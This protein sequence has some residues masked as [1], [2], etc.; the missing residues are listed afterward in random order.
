MLWGIVTRSNVDYAELM[1]EEFIQA[2][3]IFFTHRVN[4]NIPT[5]KPPPRIIPYRRF[6]KLIIY[7]LGSK[8]SIHIRP[9]SP[10][11]VTGDDFLLEMAARKPTAKEGGKK[12]TASKADKPKKPAPAKQ[13][14]PVKE[15][16]T[17]PT[18]LKKAS[19]DELGILSTTLE[20]V[21]ICE[22]ASGV[23]RILLV[24]E[25]KGKG[26]A[27]D[28]QVA[29]SLLD[30]QKPKKKNVETGANTEKSNNEADIE[31]LDVAEEQG[32]DVSKTVALEE[33][34]VEL[35]E[36]QAGLDPRK[37]PESRPPPKHVLIEEDQVGSNPRQ[38]HVALTGPNPEPMN[39]DF[40]VIVYP[41]VHESLK[42]STKEQVFIDN[43]P[44]SSRTLS[45][46]KN[47]DDTFT[48]GD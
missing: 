33:R 37:T 9:M 32:E 43:P 45:S 1:W 46:M 48:F 14:K 30:L 3:K 20:G 18:P 40:I 38:S 35:D 15:K 16:T 21:A 31:I 28:E 23:T 36:G 47:L 26:I 2:I 10:V 7:Y 24:V 22:P 29:L 41:K 19:K 44:S 12:K 27:T 17:K 4:L 25:G 5:K 42:H 11:H 13:T 8:H 6:I 34:T 39:E